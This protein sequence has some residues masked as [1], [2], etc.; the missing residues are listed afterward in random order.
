MV[1]LRGKWVEVDPREWRNRFNMTVT[2]G[3]G[4]GSQQ[5]AVQGV[6]MLGQIM[7]GITQ[8]GSGWK[9]CR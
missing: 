8:M 4:T 7:Q 2:V 1:K 6:T 9:G 3:L 5:N